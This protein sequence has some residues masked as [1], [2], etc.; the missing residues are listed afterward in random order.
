M[1]RV[2]E[3]KDNPLLAIHEIATI[4]CAETGRSL[5]SILDD[6]FWLALG[7]GFGT[8]G[9]SGFKKPLAD[10][11]RILF[12][13]AVYYNLIPLARRMLSEGCDPNPGYCAQ[14]QYLFPPPIQIAAIS[15]HIEMLDLLLE[16]C[17]E[18][19][20]EDEFRRLVQ[21]RLNGPAYRGDIEEL[22]LVLSHSLYDSSYN[23]NITAD[24]YNI[25]SSFE[26]HD[27]WK[28]ME[29]ATDPKVFQYLFEI[30]EQCFPEEIIHSGSW[31][32][33]HLTDN[34]KYGNVPMVK[35]LLDLGAVIHP[36][37]LLGACETGQVSVVDLLL[38]HGADPNVCAGN[39]TSNTPLI[40]AAKRGNISIVRKLLDHGADPSYGGNR[41]LTYPI[42]MAFRTED[43]ALIQ[44]LLD[45]GAELHGEAI[46]RLSSRRGLESMVE[47]LHELGIPKV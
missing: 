9:N 45:R 19:T 43:K 42:R 18:N 5:A 29:Y 4:I 34:A 46:M 38:S 36:I 44:L 22:N 1:Y 26:G 11:R 6:L 31:F 39:P 21:W 28:A 40:L 20:P 30:I 41:G 35:H 16:Y 2:S 13:A 12:P 25:H 47:M 15:G 10:Q 33:N 8:I 23:Y 3:E 24:E 37:A 7:R 27:I 14:W 17:R 32:G